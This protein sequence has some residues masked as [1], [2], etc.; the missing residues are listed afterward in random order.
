MTVTRCLIKSFQIKDKTMRPILLGAE[1]YTRQNLPRHRGHLSQVIYV[2]PDKQGGTHA[3]KGLVGQF[4]LNRAGST[5]SAH[6]QTFNRI[7]LS[8]GS[9]LQAA[10]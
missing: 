4:V 6:S 8:P 1:K 2:P 5:F 9:V 10:K 3:L 7:K